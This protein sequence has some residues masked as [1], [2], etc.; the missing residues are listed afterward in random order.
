MNVAIQ[1]EDEFICFY[2]NS[3]ER[4]EEICKKANIEFTEMYEVQDDE[5][6]FYSF[7]SRIWDTEY[8]EASK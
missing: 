3:T 1:T 5:M 6:E 2:T 8:I 4:A 7:D